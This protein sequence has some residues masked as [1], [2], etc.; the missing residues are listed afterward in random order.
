[1]NFEAQAA[2]MTESDVVSLLIANQRYQAELQDYKA[3][4]ESKDKSLTKASEEIAQLKHQNNWFKRQLFGVKSERRIEASGKQ[5]TLGQMPIDDTVPAASTTVKSYQRARNKKV[6]LEG[7][8]EDS[9]L[10]FDE[11][12]PVKVIE[13]KNP[14]LE[15]LA[16]S[17][18]EV[19]GEES[20]YRL[21]Q[22]PSSYVVLKYVRKTVKL[23]GEL[24]TPLAP[25]TVLEKSYA[26]VSLLAGLIIDK[27]LYHLPLYRQHQR[28]K[29]SG[30]VLSRTSLTN[31]VHRTADLLEPVYYALF[32]SILQSEVILMDET[33]IKADRKAKGKMNT[34]YFW[35]VYGELDEIAFPFSSSRNSKLISEALS[36]WG[37]TLVTD[38]YKVYDSFAA[39]VNDITHA[40]C[41]AHARRKF[42][43]AEKTEPELVAKVLD[44]IRVLYKHEEHIKLKKL[45]PDKALEYRVL[46]SK[47]VVEQFFEWLNSTFQKQVLLPNSPFTK[48]ANYTLKREQGLRVFLEYPNVPIDT[49]CLERALRPIPMGRKNWL[50]C[51]TE[52]GAK[53]V[54]VLQS[55]IQS[56]RLQAVDPYTYLVDVLQRIETHKAVDV[57]LLTPRLWKEHFAKNPLRSDL[58]LDLQ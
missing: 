18:Y 32:S 51:W 36:M 26:D 25:A 58:D 40:Q 45:K 43:E 52:I 53:Y 30:I 44:Y 6:P 19:V 56:C 23:N 55:L 29:A 28:L 47:P 10:R 35:P 17:D 21:A 39:K 16:E 12:V 38:G 5:L 13:V 2:S 48:A 31:W 49:N 34:G 11:S 8:P 57:H 24:N 46:N 41:W 3:E 33:H 20:T 9:G 50:F 15:G 4:L 37:G 42:V 1:M 27:F 14:E 7:S 22:K 54:G